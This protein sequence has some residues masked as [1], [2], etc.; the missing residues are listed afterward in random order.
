[1]NSLQAASLMDNAVEINGIKVLYVQEDI[2]P[3]KAKSKV[4]DYRDQIGSGIIVL[5]STFEEKVSYF[6]NNCKI[7]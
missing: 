5:V 6:V 7:M 4:F 3:A 1:M 2:E